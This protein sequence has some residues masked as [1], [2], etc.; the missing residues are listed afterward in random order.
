MSPNIVMGTYNVNAM[1]STMAVY[2]STFS[3]NGEDRFNSNEENGE[4]SSTNNLPTNSRVFCCKIQ[5]TKRSQSFCV[6]RYGSSRPELF[7]KKCVLRNFAK[8]T[9][10]HPECI[11]MNFAKFLRTPFL[12]KHL[13]WLL[14]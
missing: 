9:G 6:I 3:N 14:L 10:K 7:G 13:R 12:T 4:N 11:P 1:E 5:Y 2:V 8:F